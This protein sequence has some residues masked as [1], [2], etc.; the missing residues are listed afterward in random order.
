MP[1]SW[2]TL[3]SKQANRDLGGLYIIK[4]TFTA[5][6]T[7]ASIPTLTI[8]CVAAKFLGYGVKFGATGPNTMTITLTDTDGV[9]AF[10]EASVTASKRNTVSAPVPIVGDLTMAITGNDTNS[11][12]ATIILYFE[13][14][15]G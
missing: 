4:S 10:T 3:I 15:I 14:L 7:D 9:T 1:G 13:R 6:A 12:V 2:T 11:A 5:D 8:P